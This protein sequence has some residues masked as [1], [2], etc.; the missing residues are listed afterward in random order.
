M[1]IKINGEEY[2]VSGNKTVAAVLIE[3]RVGA[4]SRSVGGDP[5]YPLCGMG[6]CFECRVTVDGIPHRRSCLIEATDGM[7]VETG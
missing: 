6:I 7:E 1:K 2:P 5:R 4:F 3:A